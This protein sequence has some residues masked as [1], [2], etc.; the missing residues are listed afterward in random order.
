MNGRAFD[1]AS[2][3]LGA[4]FDVIPPVRPVL[5]QGTS[6]TAK[7]VREQARA[8]LFISCEE[9]SEAAEA[10]LGYKELDSMRGNGHPIMRV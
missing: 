10:M 8:D 6:V 2:W 3:L 9:R 7:E 4:S 1:D 5:P